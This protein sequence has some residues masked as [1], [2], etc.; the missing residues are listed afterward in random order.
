MKKNL[1]ILGYLLIT[2]AFS[3]LTS[4]AQFYNYLPYMSNY[5][6]GDVKN[7]GTGMTFTYRIQ[8]D[9]TLALST[10]LL[11][12]DN[13]G[14]VEWMKSP[15]NNFSSYTT[16]ADNSVILT[17]GRST[18]AGNR[19][20]LLQKTDSNGNIVW[21]KSLA[22][23]SADVGI[24]NIMIS[25]NNTIFATITRS[26]FSSSTYF[27]KAGVIAFDMNGQVLWTKY[28][29]NA[30]QTTEYGFTRTILAENGDFIGVADIRGSSGASANGM[31]ITRINPQGTVIFSKYIDFKTTHNQLSVTG[32]VETASNEIIFGGRLMIDQIS[33]YPN[34]MWLGKLDSAGTMLI[35]KVYSGG[36]DVGEQLHSLRYDNGTLFAYMQLYS[37]FD[38]VNKSIWIG[39]INE[40]TLAFT[41]QNATEI[42]VNSEDPY[43]NVSNSFCITSDGKPTV[44][45]GFYC[46]EKDRYFPLMQQWS[47]S[48]ASSCSALDAIQPIVDSDTNYVAAAYTPTGSFTITHAADTSEILLTN[49]TPTATANLCNGCSLTTSDVTQIQQKELFRLYPN[50]GDGLYFIDS[51]QSLNE[52]QIVIFNN[53]GSIVY[54]SKV[55]GVHQPIDL[56][57]QKSGI[58]FVK[59][60]TNDGRV[61]ISK[62]V[63]N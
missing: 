51:D 18:T 3:P 60:Q 61:A 54:E 5:L 39:T 46:V 45:A 32:L 34:T 30:A 15:S 20:A 7:D 9:S 31:M 24:G 6:R 13:N 11:H 62:L 56:S 37:P 57:E 44:A 58:Y 22:A 4:S 17:G 43:G 26:S 28:F 29:G 52:S 33:N 63:K 59:V 36:E 19:I 47:S 23:S 25:A 41:A 10:F 1:T 38:S 35:Q 16:A 50:P 48:L 14:Q 2:F 8:D 49:V 55:Q 12:T 21:T 53:L 27:S 40:Q 42:E